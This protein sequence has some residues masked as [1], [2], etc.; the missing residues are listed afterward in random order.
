MV[1]MPQILKKDTIAPNQGNITSTLTNYEVNFGYGLRMF[2]IKKNVTWN[3]RY[4][5]GDSLDKALV[6]GKIVLCDSVNSG[7]G[8]SAA[9]AVGAIMQYYLDSAFNFPLPVSC[10]GSDDGMDVSTY[11]NT[12]RFVFKNKNSSL[13]N[14]LNKLLNCIS[15]H[16]L[17]ENQKQ[18]YWKVLKKRMNKLHMWFHFHQ[19]GLTLL[20]MTF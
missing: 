5:S 4:C 13:L 20:R 17:V 10:L 7:E 19:E 11:L 1:E 18:K 8:P 15:C 3:A 14:L 6:K 16:V 12:T 2:I 9:G